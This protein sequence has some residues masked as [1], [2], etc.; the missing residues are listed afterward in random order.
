M[1]FRHSTVSLGLLYMA[2]GRAS[3]GRHHSCQPTRALRC[4]IWNT[5]LHHE[6]GQEKTTSGWT[7]VIKNLINIRHSKLLSIYALKL[8]FPPDG[9]SVLMILMEQTPPLT[10]HDVLEDC[11]SI[12]EDR[13]L[14]RVLCFSRNTRLNFSRKDYVGQI[15]AALNAIHLS[16]LVHRGISSH[17]IG[18]ASKENPSQPKMIKLC[19][20]AFYT[21]L[22]D[23]HWSSSS[24]ESTPAT[25]THWGPARVGRSWRLALER[26]AEWIVIVVHEAEGYPWRWD[27]VVKDAPRFGCG[28]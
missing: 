16:N 4:D 22:L 11:E 24:G 21:R 19:R 1:W 13:A 15:L 8:V 2:A 12:H 10:L 5:L 3:G 14:V 18:L 26:C 27:C 9:M 6:S 25:A 7:G 28:W 20:T 17:C 23:L